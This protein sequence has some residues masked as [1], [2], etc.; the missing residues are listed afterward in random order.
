M[1]FHCQ[2]IYWKRCSHNSYFHIW[3]PYC[4]SILLTGW[5]GGRP[6]SLLHL[7]TTEQKNIWTSYIDLHLKNGKLGF[8]LPSKALHS[9]RKEMRRFMKNSCKYIIKY[10]NIMQLKYWTFQIASPYL[11]IVFI[12]IFIYLYE[13]WQTVSICTHNKQQFNFNKYEYDKNFKVKIL[14]LISNSDINLR[15]L[16]FISEIWLY[17]QN[18]I[19]DFKVRILKFWV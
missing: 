12:S 16:T 13:L 9:F 11:T 17:S 8:K 10:F 6:T 4:R 5:V 14:T 2:S 1:A 3:P 15:I 18:F 19:S 7:Q